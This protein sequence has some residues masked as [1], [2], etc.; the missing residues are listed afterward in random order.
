MVE[1]TSSYGSGVFV[2]PRGDSSGAGNHRIRIIHDLRKLNSYTIRDVYPL[3]DIRSL[4]QS[5]QG[6]RYFGL[7]DLKDSYQSIVIK[8]EDRKKAAVVTAKRVLVPTRMSYGFTNAPAHFSRTITRVVGKVSSELEAGLSN[9]MDDIILYA[10][11]PEGLVDV[12][13][14]CLG[15]LNSAGFKVNLNKLSIFKKESS[16]N[17]I[18]L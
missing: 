15:E 1:E 4:L 12:L 11:T 9:Y 10:N 17:L 2:R 6:K 3:P 5:L 18:L 13:D 7:I 16:F 8:P 14:K